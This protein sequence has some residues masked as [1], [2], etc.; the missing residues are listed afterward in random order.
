LAA[1]GLEPG[2]QGRAIKKPTI[3]GSSKPYVLPWA[4]GSRLQAIFNLKTA[5]F[6]DMI[7]RQKIKRVQNE[8]RDQIRTCWRWDLCD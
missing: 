6:F 8:K 3:V 5:A 1:Q 4:P 7:E 2:A